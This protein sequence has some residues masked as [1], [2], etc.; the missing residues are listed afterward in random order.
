MQKNKSKTFLLG[1][2]NI[3]SQGFFLLKRTLYVIKEGER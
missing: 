1:V 3:I 2:L